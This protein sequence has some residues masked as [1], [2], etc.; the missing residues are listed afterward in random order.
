MAGVDACDD[1]A[2]AA[3]RAVAAAS[4]SPGCA[5][6]VARP[7][8]VHLDLGFVEP[9]VPTG[10]DAS[11]SGARPL[12]ATGSGNASA[13]MPGAATHTLPAQAATVVVA[14]D[15]AGPQA[16]VLAEDAGWPL[17]AEPSSGAF[18]RP[19]ATKVSLNAIPAYRLLL[20]TPV[21]QHISRVITFGRPT[22]SRPVT[23]LL[24]RPD[25]E[26]I[27]VA[28]PGEAGPP[29]VHQRLEGRVDAS[30]TCVHPDWLR[31]WQHAGAA[32]EQ[33]L[34][35]AGSDS[36]GVKPS[37]AQQL[38]PLRV[39]ELAVQA[40]RA[41][42]AMVVAASNA[43]RD[44]DLVAHRLPP[45]VPVWANR[46][47]AGI[48]GTIG[49]AIGVAVGMRRRTRVLAGDLA[50]LHDVGSLS[51]PQMERAAVPAV[52]IIVLNDDGGGIFELLEPAGQVPG[53]GRDTF[54]R[55]FGTPHGNGI[56][57]LCA[58]FAVPHVVVRDEDGLRAQLARPP[59]GVSVVEVGLDRRFRRRQAARLQGAVRTRLRAQA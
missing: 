19:G 11:P 23:A 42:D 44:L 45:G 10:A 52:Q 6:V 2:T 15:G 1:W 21:A 12:P 40:C 9:L 46:G 5:A 48:D 27:H 37:H 59:A 20:D 54:E 51:V 30:E 56:G 7:G 43:V 22:L 41:E 55:F 34:D 33:I 26:V 53:F 8:P 32:A 4:G 25:V 39:A 14:G 35:S 50:F 57:A 3:A 31:I 38:S 47:L 29:R 24:N 58:G 18:A 16:T 17:F 36:A 49:T 28:R 13:P